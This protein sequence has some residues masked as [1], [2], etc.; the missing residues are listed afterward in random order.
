MPTLSAV[1]L[2]A[3]LGSRYGSNKLL[4]PVEGVPLYRRAFSAL[5]ARGFFRAAVVS[6]YDEILSEASNSRYI[7]VENPRPQEG[8][9]LSVKLGLTAVAEGSDAVLFAVCDQPWLTRESVERLTA[10]WRAHPEHICALGCGGKRGNPCI[11]PRKYYDELLAL[12]GDV[13]GSRVIR[14]HPSDLLLVEAPA[15]ELADLDR[16]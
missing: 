15:R 9:S 14:A 6:C 12:T 5:P 1:L 13:G 3:G 4:V 11:F 2:A 8:Q 10:R 7:P 16:P